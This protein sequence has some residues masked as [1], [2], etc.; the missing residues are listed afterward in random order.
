I[1][2]R[3]EQERFLNLIEASALLHQHQRLK[4]K[5]ASG[6]AFIVADTKDFEIAAGLAADSI[7]RAGDELSTTARSL[8]ALIRA[9][10]TDGMTMDD[11]KALRP[12]WT[13]YRFRMGLDE[14]LKLEILTSPRGGRG[15]AREYQL[16]GKEAEA[17]S[18]QSV[19]LLSEAEVGE[20]AK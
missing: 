18:V 16:Q 12:D 10:N 17:P 14:L 15:R 3:R 5:N 13:R 6:E 11:L 4:S 1:R 2:H 8:L 20:L 19:R 7:G 9:T